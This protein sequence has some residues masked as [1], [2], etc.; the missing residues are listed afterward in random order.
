MLRDEQRITNKDFFLLYFYNKIVQFSKKAGFTLLSAGQF[1]FSR[2]L[3][4]FP[5][6]EGANR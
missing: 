4:L 1:L 5:F 6:S 2:D 3:I